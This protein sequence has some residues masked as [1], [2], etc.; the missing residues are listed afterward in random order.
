[1]KDLNTNY[2]ICG[3]PDSGQKELFLLLTDTL[4]KKYS[5]NELG[6]SILDNPIKENTINFNLFDLTRIDQLLETTKF[7]ICVRD[8]RDILCDKFLFNGLETYVND[9]NCRYMINDLINYDLI[10][11]STTSFGLRYY[12]NFIKSLSEE[13]K[14]NCIV[15]TYEQLISD[16]ITT[17][18]ELM[19]FDESLDFESDFILD[20][21]SVKFSDWE[22]HVDR[23]KDQI[24]KFPEM[25][26]YVTYF[27][28]EQDDTWCVDIYDEE[29]VQIN[30]QNI[31]SEMNCV[32]DLIKTSLTSVASSNTTLNKIKKP[33][34]NQIG[35]RNKIGRRRK[36]AKV[37][38]IQAKK[39]IKNQVNIKFKASK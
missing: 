4:S 18:L 33:I 5:F 26:D 3:L 34:R 8:I 7:I 27:N 35:S 6:L 14:L 39:K 38:I 36:I 19:E 31:K 11:N 17:Q 30:A 23:I 9:W 10:I 29:Q 25:I 2:V 21:S 20:E 24:C 22:Q 28:F 32:H 12:G 37:P 13:Q 16:S 15:I 1:M